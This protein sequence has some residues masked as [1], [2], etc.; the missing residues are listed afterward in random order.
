MKNILIIS[1]YAESILN[2]RKELIQKLQ[3]KSIEV[4]VAAPNLQVTSQIGIR[5]N[6]IGVIVHEVSLNRTSLNPIFDLWTIKQIYD[7]IK[8][9]KPNY[10][11]AYTIKPVV[12]GMFAA[13]LNNIKNSF[14]LITGLGYSFTGEPKGI[15]GLLRK[16]LINLF[17][18]GL[19]N[20]KI[21]FFQNPDDRALFRSLKIINSSQKSIVVNG[22]GVD[23]K[24]FSVDPF[25]ENISFLMIA[26]LLGDKGIREYAQAAKQIKLKHPNIIF[27]IAGWIDENPDAIK[28]IEL[29]KWVK[30]GILSFLGKLEDVRPSIANKSVFVLPSYREGTPRTVLE[31]MAMGRPI[32]TTDVPGC[33]ETV[34]NGVNGYL[35]Q[36]KSVDAL[37]IAMEK[38]IK[39]PKLCLQMGKESRRIA[40]EKYDVHKVNAVMLNEMGIA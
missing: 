27:A 3:S 23:V 37:V 22:S 15:R 17:K 29:D 20:T 12:Y 5:L 11:L 9:I 26:R 32:I 16:F 40:E 8:M 19:R 21:I 7:L 25:P 24:H 2:F 35:I 4:H 36:V 6:Q 33:R 14:A 1:S 13:S 38:L 31:A 10:V 28:Q 18:L 39:N 34:V 30:D